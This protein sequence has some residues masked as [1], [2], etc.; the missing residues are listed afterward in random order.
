MT[1][2]D[3]R[4][5]L[6][7]RLGSVLSDPSNAA[8]FTQKGSSRPGHLVDYLLSHSTSQAVPSAVLGNK[9]AVQMDTL[10]EIIISGLSG[11]WP[12]ARSK[13]DG[14]SLGDVWPVVCLAKQDGAEAFGV[15]VSFHK[16][17][18]WLTYSLIE[19]YVPHSLVLRLVL[20]FGAGRRGPS[21]TDDLAHPQ[22]GDAPCVAVHRQGAD[23]WLARVP[24]W[25]VPS[26]S[27][28]IFA[29]L[30]ARD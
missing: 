23:D 27:L 20:V 22:H 5:Q 25:C 9:V 17:S 29:L 14:V 10:W 13:I 12:A 16:L 11:V 21:Q 8:Y 3:G 19:V 7:V 26:F 6:L 30:S 4:A 28:E 1:G 24:Q 15:L 18:Q 2:I